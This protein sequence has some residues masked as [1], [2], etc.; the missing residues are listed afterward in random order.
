MTC[1][2][3]QLI[4]ASFDG[5]VVVLTGK[6][7]SMTRQEAQK[8][9]EDRGGRCTSSVTKKTTL[10]IAGADPGSKYEKA[11]QLGTHIISEAEFREW[12]ERE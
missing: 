10:V 7:E 11:Q 9:V 2:K 8:A 3:R 12:L 5:E 4:N 1:E 6:L